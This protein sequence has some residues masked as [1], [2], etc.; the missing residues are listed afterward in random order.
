M[1]VHDYLAMVAYVSEE[2]ITD[3]T[4]QVYRTNYDD[5]YL[6]QVGMEENVQFLA[7]REITEQLSNGIGFSIKN[8]KWYGWSHRAIY[9]F[10]IGSTCKPGDCH[11]VP[12]NEQDEINDCI[13]FWSDP[14]SK[15]VK[16]ILLRP[17]LIEVSWERRSWPEAIAKYWFNY[18]EIDL[19][20]KLRMLWHYQIKPWFTEPDF[21]DCRIKDL[22]WRFKRMLFER[23]CQRTTILSEYDPDNFGRGEWTAC[24]WEDAKQMAIDFHEGVS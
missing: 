14:D 1:D 16:A 22:I 11:Y 17:G 13:R 18:P 4:V 2:V 12:A 10:G 21:N 23:S 24:T 7:D 9:G 6:T 15:K 8:K 3:H 20:F 19:K 5:S